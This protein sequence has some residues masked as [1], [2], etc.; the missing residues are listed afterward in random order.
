MPSMKYFFKKKILMYIGNTFFVWL[1]Q[2][3]QNKNVYNSQN[4]DIM[5]F[6]SETV[7]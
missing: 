1:V 7:T 5:I 6:S 3:W 2:N 4:N